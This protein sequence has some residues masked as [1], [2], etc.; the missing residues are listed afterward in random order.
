MITMDGSPTASRSAGGDAIPAEE[1]TMTSP[2]QAL[3]DEHEMFRPQIAQ[4]LQTADAVGSSPG[5]DL[6]V[7]LDRIYAFLTN[8]LLPHA[9]AEEVSLYPEVGRAL[10]SH[11]ATLTMCHDHLVIAQLT[12]E[13]GIL[14]MGVTDATPTTDQA[15]AL[16]RVLY[17][18]HA[19]I[20]T[21]FAKEEGIYLPL[22]EHHLTRAEAKRV[23]A[24]L[25][26]AAHTAS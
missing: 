18:L 7:A 21:H 26:A 13:L 12:E 22:L 2:L 8:D 5:K 10:G 9:R 6:R 20:S 4:L 17:S 14:R 16:R 24:A 3:R 25:H 11:E 23:S 19:L 15:R 1:Y